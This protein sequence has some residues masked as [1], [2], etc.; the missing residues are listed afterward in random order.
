H[1]EVRFEGPGIVGGSTVRGHLHE[2]RVTVLDGSSVLARHLNKHITYS[3]VPSPGGTA[4]KSLATPVGMAVSSDGA[5]LYV[6]GFGSQKVGVY[7]TVKLEN[8]TFDP[9]TS[10]GVTYVPLASGGPSGVVLDETHQCLY[11]LTRFDNS[12]S[13]VNTMTLA[14]EAA[15]KRPL[16]NPEPATVT[17]GRSFLYDAAFTS[18]NGEASCSSCHI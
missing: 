1:N 10:N 3:T 12:V 11:V 16:Y 9:N 8:D 6:T 4:A 18:S 2:A 7:D 13:V 17:A 15:L 5:T 14:E